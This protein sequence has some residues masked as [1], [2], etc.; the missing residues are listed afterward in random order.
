VS[1]GPLDID[2]SRLSVYGPL[3]RTVRDAAA[4]LDAVA[5]PRP[6]DPDPL[7]L[8]AEPFLRA[9]GRDPGRMRIGRFVE[10]PVE[11]EIDPQLLDAWERTSRLLESLGHEVVDIDSP[12]PPEAV[13]AFETLWAVAAHTAPI[14]PARE[15]EL[16]PLTRYLRSRG[17][18]ISG[19]QYAQA[20]G[21]LGL[22]ARQGIATT[23]QFDAVL[24]PTLAMLPRPVGWFDRDGD[25]A[26]DFERR[27]RFTPFTAVVNT[28]GQPAISLPLYQSSEGLPIG[29]MLVGR[30]A[31]EATLLRLSA[32]LEAAAPWRD[33]HPAIWT[34]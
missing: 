18:Q 1:K 19:P 24:T 28:T 15:A 29:I 8:P 20:V 7:P 9:C 30:P 33:R 22:F 21:T 25:P 16:R 32:Q 5:T 14:D 26:A 23:A 31:D 4:F 27:K 12:V 10:P 34:A 11:T 2:S 3:A 6:G 13:P 17:E